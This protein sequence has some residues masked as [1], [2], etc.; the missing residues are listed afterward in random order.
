MRQKLNKKLISLN[1]NLSIFNV[2]NRTNDIDYIMIDNYEKYFNEFNYIEL[3]V[4]F[5]EI[6]TQFILNLFILL[7]Q[8]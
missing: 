5:G 1:G 7:N 4:I 6:I 2:M 3:L 8:Q